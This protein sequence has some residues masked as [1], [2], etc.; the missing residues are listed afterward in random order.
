[1]ARIQFELTD[2]CVGFCR[3]ESSMRAE[4]ALPLP[5]EFSENPDGIR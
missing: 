3:Q 4:G 5:R 2:S 1:M